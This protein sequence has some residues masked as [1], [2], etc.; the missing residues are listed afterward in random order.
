M[1]KEARRRVARAQREAIASDEA[2]RAA[3]DIARLFFENEITSGIG[4]VGCYMPI[5]NEISPLPLL[6]ALNRRGVVCA[7]PVVEGE[8]SE[9][10]ALVFRRYCPDDGLVAGAYGILEPQPDKQEL[11]PEML[12]VPLLSFDA[13]GTRLGYGAGHYDR[14][15][16]GIE[17]IAVG[18]GY[19]SQQVEGL[20]REAHDV[21]LDWILTEKFWLACRG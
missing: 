16:S 7:L 15:L 1:D 10:S 4:S 19:A 21:A 5:R 8:E 17:T 2:Q 9:G 18:L 12:L 14:T 13:R 6:S 20:P 3:Q 11:E